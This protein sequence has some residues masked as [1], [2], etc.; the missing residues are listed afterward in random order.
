MNREHQLTR[1]DGSSGSMVRLRS[2]GRHTGQN[3]APTQLPSAIRERTGCNL[4]LHAGPMCSGM[5]ATIQCTASL[6]STALI[7]AKRVSMEALQRTSR[8]TGYAR[9]RLHPF[10]EVLLFAS[11]RLRDKFSW[12]APFATGPI[13]APRS[14]TCD[15]A[16]GHDR[17]A[18]AA[19]QTGE[20]ALNRF[21]RDSEG[22]SECSRFTCELVF[23]WQ[24]LLSRSNTSQTKRF[25]PSRR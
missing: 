1:T 17:C 4:E 6:R 18:P 21:G 2:S 12:S 10:A 22:S 20:N 5:G 11:S 3:A 9:R 23:S 14:G 15:V 19:W 24:P 13:D 8:H 16:V 7:W 25:R